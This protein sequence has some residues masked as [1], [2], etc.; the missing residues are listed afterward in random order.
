M[1]TFTRRLAVVRRLASPNGMTLIEVM[2]ATAIFTVAISS[3][4]LGIASTNYRTYWATYEQ[5]ATKSASERLEQVRTVHWQPYLTNTMDGLTTSNF[6]ADTV[7]LDPLL[8]GAT[9]ITASRSVSFTTISV[10]GAPQYKVV[11]SSVV[12][13]YRNKGPFTNSLI[14]LAL[15]K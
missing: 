12:W 7:V 10:T 15:Q 8:S 11:L 3:V 6:P 2:I 14:S 5:L 9:P 1:R 4:L 13:S